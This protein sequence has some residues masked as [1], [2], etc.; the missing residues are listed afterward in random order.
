[1]MLL[2]ILFRWAYSPQQVLENTCAKRNSAP[3]RC[4]FFTSVLLSM[5]GYRLSARLAAWLCT[6]FQIPAHPIRLKTSLVGLSK[7]AKENVMSE[8]NIDRDTASQLN[9][10]IGFN[11]A[12]TLS[13]VIF[14]LQDL[15]YLASPDAHSGIELSPIALYHFSN[16]LCSALKFEKEFI[17]SGESE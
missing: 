8:I 14:G 3:V 16:N 6:C 10:F 4:G 9:S 1:M 11:I 2:A 13:R 15:G 12:E 5:G 7:L 17:E